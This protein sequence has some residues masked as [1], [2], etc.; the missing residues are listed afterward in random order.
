MPAVGATLTRPKKDYEIRWT[1]TWTGSS[2]TQYVGGINENILPS[3]NIRFDSG[4][5]VC[6]ATG[7]NITMGDG[8]DVDRFVTAT[9]LSSYLDLT[10]ATRYHDGANRKLTITPSGTF[11]GSIS[12]TIC[13][14]ILD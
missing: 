13:G 11:T 4:T 5:L 8:S 9:A 7:V 1:H 3:D 6:T 14:K 2:E 12:L 10:F